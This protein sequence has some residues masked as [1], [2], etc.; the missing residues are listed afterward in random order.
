MAEQRT[1]LVIA[2]DTT[3]TW[4]L[5]ELSPNAKRIETTFYRT[6]HLRA[7]ALPWKISH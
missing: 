4:V 5:T 7:R 1:A 3:S 2:E 6:P